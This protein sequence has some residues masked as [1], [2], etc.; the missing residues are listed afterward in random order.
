[1][2]SLNINI[3]PIDL[4]QDAEITLLFAKKVKTVTKYS[5]FLFIFLEKKTL[6]LSKKIKLNQHTIKMQDSQQP[7]YR[8]IY[9][10][11]PVKF[12]IFKIYIKTNLANSFI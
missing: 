3:M 11:S 7:F 8:P 2:R 9:S 1:M 5:D 12:E 4:T 6:I 10:I